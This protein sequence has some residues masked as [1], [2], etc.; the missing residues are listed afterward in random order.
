MADDPQNTPAELQTIVSAL[1]Q[2][3]IKYCFY[4]DGENGPGFYH[5]TPEDISI[6]ID[7]WDL[8]RNEKWLNPKGEA[9]I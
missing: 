2:A 1:T 6:S 5:K 3:N 7:V 8:E 4:Q 9:D